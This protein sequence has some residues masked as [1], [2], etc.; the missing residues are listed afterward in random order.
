MFTYFHVN[1][2]GIHINANNKALN[3]VLIELRDSLNL[4]MSFNDK[5]LSEYNISINKNFNTL[6]EAFNFLL[7]NT[8]LTV[9]KSGSVYL[10][11]SKKSA[12]KRTVF[13]LSGVIQDAN[14]NERL[15][16]SNILINNI[17]CISDEQGNFNFQTET[18]SIF[19]L[20]VSYLGYQIFD[21]TVLY[22]TNYIINIQP[23]DV[24]LDE[25][26]VSAYQWLYS[27]QTGSKA[28]LIRINHK[29]AMLI[30]GSG[31]NSIFNLLRLQPGIMAS[32]EQTT[33]MVI[34]GSYS[35]QSQVNFD[36]I[37]LFGLKNYNDNISVVNPYMAKDIRILKGGFDASLGERVGGIVDVTGIDGSK[38]KAGFNA[39]INN[40]TLNLLAKTFV[41]SKVSIVGAYRQTYYNLYSPDDFSLNES[42][43]NHFMGNSI[44]VVPDYKF[45]DGNLKISGQLDNGDTYFVSSFFGQDLFSYTI[46]QAHGSYLIS[47][48][49]FEK[50]RQ[51][52]INSNYNKVWKGLGSTSVN[53]A[54]SALETEINDL[55]NSSGMMK[56]YGMENEGIKTLN[57]ITEVKANINT[58]IRINK[59]NEFEFGTAI[60]KNTTHIQNNDSYWNSKNGS[61]NGVLI[62]LFL[63]DTYSPFNNFDINTG[64][65]T[66]Y[67]LQLQKIY[68]QPR[69][70][71]AYKPTNKIQFNTAWGVYNQFVAKNAIV[72]K[73]NNYSYLWM[74]SNGNN[75][76]VIASQHFILGGIFHQKGFSFS[77]ESFYKTTKG[78]TQLKQNNNLITYYSGKSKATGVDFF[79]KQ[80]YKGHSFWVSY[81]LSQTLEWFPYFHNTTYKS[82]LHNQLHEIKI[83]GIVN[84]SPFIIS[85]NYVY[86]SGFMQNTTISNNNYPYKRV[87]ISG[88]YK[89]SFKRIKVET[90]VSV[91]NLLNYENIK[92]ENITQIPTHENNTVNV[93]SGATPFTPTVFF[94]VSF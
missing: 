24:I 70:N 40:M 52:G 7:K 75:I 31:D 65:R 9:E 4:N 25:V 45:K 93:Y 34:W 48:N 15:P 66:D 12:Q 63:Q 1:G 30:P 3:L 64:L 18:D 22:G 28:G 56:D 44:L 79:C 55:Q 74:I 51:Y 90:G 71:I 59:K 19:Q 23:K 42:S 8:T 88:I 35:G 6:E 14:N 83:S 32:G 68:I 38:E 58:S 46:E 89:F 20:A 72:D 41:G 50:N 10:F 91:L 53:M 26:V 69:I 86:G 73:Y 47:R 11:Y 21:T 16:Y 5:E 27:K 67:S 92:Y 81:T 39:N 85:A 2:Q 84:L 54:Y 61:N 76:P 29:V 37:T 60:Y 77:V 94:N 78:I 36:G 33:E 57:N 17:G 82:A 87:D 13:K 62:M 80:E 43:E 49:L